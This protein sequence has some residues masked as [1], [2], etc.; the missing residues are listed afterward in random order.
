MYG[1]IDL[2]YDNDDCLHMDAALYQLMWKLPPTHEGDLRAKEWL[3]DQRGILYLRHGEPIQR[4]AGRGARFSS[5][6]FVSGP[7]ADTPDTTQVWSP[8]AKGQPVRTFSSGLD[9]PGLVPYQ[10][11]TQK[12]ESWLYLIEN[13]LRLVHFRGS[14]A[15]GMYDATTLSGFLPYSVGSWLARSGALPEYHAAGERIVSELRFQ[16]RRRM[17]CLPPSNFDAPSCW[18]EVQT[19]DARSRSD[20]RAA[21]HNDSDSPPLVYPW[22]SVIQMFALGED[23][24]RSG[25]ALVTFALGGDSLHA[26]TTAD[27]RVLYQIHF[28]A[29]AWNGA[30]GQTVS[31]DTTRRF[32]RS[33]PLTSTER[34]VSWLEI[35]LPGGQWELG[36]RA[37]QE[38]D[39][40]GAYALRRDV[41]IGT[42]TALS[43]SDIVTGL[44]GSP[45][46]KA[47]DGANF[48]INTTRAWPTGTPAE[49]YFEVHGVPVNASYRTTIAV[50]P[51]AVKG[52]QTIQLTSTDRSSGAVNYV[53]RSLGLEHLVAGEYELSV[54]VEAGTRRAVRTGAILLLPP[55]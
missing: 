37:K 42:G 43:L 28:R 8:W 21:A 26:T 4:I 6:D 11:S 47:T 39:S 13:Q 36:V 14:Y 5:E 38:S 22:Q 20:A 29:V 24:D 3:L 55:R 52:G 16:N 46:W 19:A 35:P 27:G 41:E 31:L 50:R 10:M 34:L 54:T 53:R 45:P 18:K 40:S 44:P 17:S 49:L 33:T 51:R 9:T 12:T 1:R 30:T 23:R 15:I 32:V 7:A 25:K 2:F 48:P